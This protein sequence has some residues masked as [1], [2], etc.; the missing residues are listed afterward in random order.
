MI[1]E[2]VGDLAT[3]LRRICYP[4]GYR[5][6][7]CPRCEGRGLHVHD[8]RERTL[9][10][11]NGVTTT[12]IV[13]HRCVACRAI[14]QILPLFIARWLWRTWDV[15][16][17]Q[18][19]APPSDTARRVPARTRRRWRGRLRSSARQLVQVLATSGDQQMEAIA[20]SLDAWSTRAQAVA[21]Y[22]DALGRAVGKRLCAVAALVHRLVP[23]VRLM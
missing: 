7:S 12:K 9:R 15:V 20:T 17:E 1:V 14:W 4:D 8:Y 10:G 6:S 19:D 22:A 5:P 23:G 2:T 13:R 3:H 11:A 16:E 21:A 18:V